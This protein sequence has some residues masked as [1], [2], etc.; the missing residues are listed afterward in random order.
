MFSI[1]NSI[2]FVNTVYVYISSRQPQFLGQQEMETA[3][4]MLP[5]LHHVVLRTVH[6][7]CMRCFTSTKLFVLC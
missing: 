7:T 3:Y 2:I 4:T 1:Y 5:P 6:L